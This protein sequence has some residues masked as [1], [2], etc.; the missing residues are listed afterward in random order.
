MPK[1]AYKL[2]RIPFDQEKGFM[3]TTSRS[4]LDSG[5]H[6]DLRNID[7]YFSLLFKNE[8]DNIKQLGLNPD[9]LTLT[10]HQN[11]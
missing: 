9:S 8:A 5:T 2:T 1:K 7:K 4:R 10:I 6:E 11:I 3:Q